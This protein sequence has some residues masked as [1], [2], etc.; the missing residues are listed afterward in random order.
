MQD[1]GYTLHRKERANTV[2]V[3]VRANPDRRTNLF[4]QLHMSSVCTTVMEGK[5]AVDNRITS[6]FCMVQF[7]ARIGKTYPLTH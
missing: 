4:L 7:L 6:Y 2:A 5:H 3:F 1:R